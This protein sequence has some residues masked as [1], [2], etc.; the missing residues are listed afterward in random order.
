MGR[1]SRNPAR[2]A[3]DLSGQVAGHGLHGCGADG[4]GRAGRSAAPAGTEL[5]TL[6]GDPQ[7]PCSPTQSRLSLFW[8][9]SGPARPS[10]PSRL[11]SP[12]PPHPRPQSLCPRPAALSPCLQHLPSHLEALR[13]TWAPRGRGV[14]QKGRG[15]EIGRGKEAFL[16]NEKPSVCVSKK[17][18]L[19]ELPDP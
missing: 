15:V 16:A 19:E 13:L 11:L 5:P 8:E 10:A 2:F 18:A 1:G 4:R 17:C 3:A 14:P 7:P 12:P 9:E 6:H